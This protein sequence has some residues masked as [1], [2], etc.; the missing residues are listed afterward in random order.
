MLL[1]PPSEGKAPGGEGPPWKECPHG[2]PALDRRRARVRNAVRHALRAG[3]DAD[4]A[5]LLGA[6]GATLQ[7]ALADWQALDRAPTM[8]AWRRY[9]GVVWNALSPATLTRSGMRALEQRVLVPSGLWGLLRADD[10]IPAYRLKMS[11]RV[12]PLGPL[13]PFWRA[14]I[15]RQISLTADG[16]PIVDLLPAEHAAAVDLAA[17]RAPVVRVELVADSPDGVRRAVG[18][19]GKH[20]KGMLARA[21]LEHG[22]RTAED[23]ADLPLGGH[24]V[25][26]AIRDGDGHRVV[27]L[28][29]A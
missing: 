2:F 12:E 16:A 27:T 25:P 13:A 5:R 1:L 19:A 4:G 24:L 17:L 29:M 18:H 3:D 9:T 21:I 14:S 20:A 11:S 22:A 26:V 6:R 7:G 23:V 8:A 10:A 15:T 28:A